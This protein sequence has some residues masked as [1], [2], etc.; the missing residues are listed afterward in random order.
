MKTVRT[1]GFEDSVITVWKV[2]QQS[3][4]WGQVIGV[5]D[6]FTGGLSMA[7]RHEMFLHGQIASWIRGKITSVLQV[8]DT[9]VIKPVKVKTAHKHQLLRK[10]LIKLAALENTR[11]VFDCGLYEIMRTL[12]DVIRECIQEFRDADTLRKAMVQNCFLELRP[13]IEKGKF[14]KTSEQEW[15]RDMTRGSHRMKR[16]WV[17]MRFNNFDEETSMPK[18]F[19][20]KVM[21]EEEHTCLAKQD[22]KRCLSS[23]KEMQM[24]GQLSNEDFKEL[25]EEPWFEL[26]ISD[27]QGIEGLEAFEELMKTPAQQRLARGIDPNLKTQKKDFQ[28][29]KEKQRRREK[30]RVSNAEVKTE[31]R[32]VMRDLKAQRFSLA[33]ISSKCVKAEVGKGKK[34]AKS[35]MVGA[36]AK[37]LAKAKAAKKVTQAK[38][39]EAAEALIIGPV[40][41]AYLGLGKGLGPVGFRNL[42]MQFLSGSGLVANPIGG[43]FAFTPIEVFVA[44]PLW[45]SIY[46]C[47]VKEV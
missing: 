46:L 34:T 10:E 24:T 22:Q 15:S 21:P 20:N 28:K 45:S 30:E 8:A 11:A 40:T 42:I 13:N 43:G 37:A 2:R 27:F 31:A 33:Q 26:A 36:M 32:Q 39:L 23:W 29:S 44:N 12:A 3:K 41:I 14:E 17:D 9:H 16:S 6:M 35:K 1:R 18:R 5:R 19:D 38:E 7:A 4:K 25:Q 47:F